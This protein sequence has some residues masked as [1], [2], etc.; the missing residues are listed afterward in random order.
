MTS[1]KTDP[2]FCAQ[3]LAQN[4]PTLLRSGPGAKRALLCA[5][6]LAQNGHTL[7]PYGLAQNG[8]ILCAYDLAQNGHTLCALDGP[9]PKRTTA[10][11]ITCSAWRCAPRKL[12]SRSLGACHKITSPTASFGRGSA[13]RPAEPDERE[14][15]ASEQL[16]QVADLPHFGS[17]SRIS[18][19]AAT[20]G[21]GP[22]VLAT[23]FRGL[24]AAARSRFFRAARVRQAS[25]SH[26]VL[27]AAPCC[28][29]L[30]LR[31]R[32]CQ[33]SAGTASAPPRPARPYSSVVF[34][35]RK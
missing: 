30:P 10:Q 17:R 7:C 22:P 27:L 8:R 32:A 13:R 5:Y 14:E 23:L 4:G 15:T 18:S 3:D 6:D 9:R 21:S 12:D 33:R 25:E 1:R 34:L 20:T 28:S 26:W 19:G 24:T 35:R 29:L 16:W 11:N 31:R 2:P